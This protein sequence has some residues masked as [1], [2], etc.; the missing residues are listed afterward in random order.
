MS[1]VRFTYLYRDGSNFK[2][3]ADVVFPNPDGLDLQ[4]ITRAVSDAVEQDGLFVAHQVRIPEVF[5]YGK[6]DANA[7][8]HCYHEFYA[9]ES[10]S[11]IPTDRFGRSIG[12]FIAELHAEAGRGWMPFDPFDRW[13]RLL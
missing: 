5:L 4:V 2:S 13:L 1:N 11:E 12:E 10:T 3:W 9:V 6:G 7:D 8:D